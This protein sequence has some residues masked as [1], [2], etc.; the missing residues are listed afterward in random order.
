MLKY[1]EFYIYSS[2]RIKGLV[3][4]IKI[5]RGQQQK[6]KKTLFNS[7]VYKRS[8]YYLNLFEGFVKIF[9][10]VKTST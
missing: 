7:Y 2:Q 3:K 1:D 9:L 8:G 5:L 10:Y 4:G 6:E